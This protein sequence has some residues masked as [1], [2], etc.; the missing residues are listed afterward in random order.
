MLLWLKFFL[1]AS[2]IIITGS[3]LSIF[4]D[5]IAEKTGTGRL[6]I[7]AAIIPII[8]TLPE[9][10]S[11]ISAALINAPNLALGD[12]FGSNMFNIL[13][14]AAIDL[15]LIRSSSFFSKVSTHNILTITLG[16]FLISVAGLFIIVNIPFI[17]LNIGVNSII[18]FIFYILSI[19]IIFINSKKKNKE[20]YGITEENYK[21]FSLSKTY[22]KFVIVSLIIIISTWE[23]INS[24]KALA[25]IT[26]LGTT[27]WGTF[28]LAIITSLPEFACAITAVRI[29]AYDLAIGIIFGANIIN[30]TIPF[31]SDIFYSGYPIL[32]DISN[33]HLISIFTVIVLSIIVIINILYHPKHIYFKK[34]I[35]SGFIVLLYFVSILLI[36]NFH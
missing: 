22:I 30:A 14:I 27:F 21:D 5:I 2:I 28:F 36:F 25:H 19:F 26:G 15:F 35:S 13:I 20:N 9:I 29:K 24:S 6:W 32:N 12:Y 18:L 33:Y 31:F 23:M 1:S 16:L 7:G 34:V 3:K 8:T 11:G 4:G 17:I 10:S